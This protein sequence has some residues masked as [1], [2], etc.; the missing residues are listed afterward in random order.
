[1]STE[2]RRNQGPARANL[3]DLY[4]RYAAWLRGRMAKQFGAEKADD[5]VQE[6]YLRM[7]RYEGEEVTHPAGL[8]IRVARNVALNETRRDRVR[9]ALAVALDDPDQAL[10]VGVR[11]DQEEVVLL[12]Q[13]VLS[14]PQTY[15]DVFVL[16]RFAGLN[17]HQIAHR[18]GLSI[19]TVE[20]R[21]SKALAYCA[22]KLIDGP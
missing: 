20:W 6:T 14:M 7:R 17:Y 21:M 12:K 13:V 18:L 16:N 11:P 10:R 9:G 1:M 22:A 15:R 5:L 3:A 19:K 8:L 2:S 4:R